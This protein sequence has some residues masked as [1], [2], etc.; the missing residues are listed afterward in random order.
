LYTQDIAQASGAY[1]VTQRQSGAMVEETQKTTLYP[2][3]FN[4]DAVS[5]ADGSGNFYGH[6]YQQDF[7]YEKDLLNGA[8]TYSKGSQEVVGTTDQYAYN[9]SGALVTQTTQSN[10]S[11]L[12]TDTLGHCFSRQL[13]ANALALTTLVDGTDC[14]GTNKP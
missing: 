4:Y 13:T 14:G 1:S 5:N 7:E 11:Y 9:A 2:F 8:A 3:T 10:G 6:V 12:S